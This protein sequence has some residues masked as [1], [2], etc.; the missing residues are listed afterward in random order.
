RDGVTVNPAFVHGGGANNV[1]PDR[2]V[3]RFNVRI[4]C[5]ED[6][7]W[8]NTRLD[9]LL[10]DLTGRDGIAVERHGRFGRKPKILDARQQTLFELVAEC[11]RELG[12]DIVWHPTGGCCDG[13]N[14]AAAGLPNV[15]T[16]G[17]VGGA[18]HSS[19]EYMGLDSLVSRAKLA[20]LVMARLAANG[21]VSQ[22]GS[23]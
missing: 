17:V 9:A 10:A 7:Q 22:D 21:G 1:V 6:E 23:E 12:E 3:L 19:D 13:N 14:L 15:D 4:Q 2:G 18:I 20:A 5:I 8:F 16:L 11:G